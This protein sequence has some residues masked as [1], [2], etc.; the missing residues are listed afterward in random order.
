MYSFL[1]LDNFSQAT[2]FYG[3]EIK[4]TGGSG[5]EIQLAVRIIDLIGSHRYE[6]MRYYL[7]LVVLK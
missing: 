3:K 6:F 7:Y 5:E 2:H 4:V 1:D